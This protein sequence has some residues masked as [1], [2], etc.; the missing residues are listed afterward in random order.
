VFA[1]EGNDDTVTLS[2]QVT[3][4]ESEEPAVS[5]A[6]ESLVG[7][8]SNPPTLRLKRVQAGWGMN[9]TTQGQSVVL[10]AVGPYVATLR[11]ADVTMTTG[12]IVVRGGALQLYPAATWPSDI[13]PYPVPSIVVR[14]SPPYSG[15]LVGMVWSLPPL[16][17]Q[18]G[19]DVE[20]TTASTSTV[21]TSA[22]TWT[23]VVHRMSDDDSPSSVCTGALNLPSLDPGGQPVTRGVSWPTQ[24][25]S[26]PTVLCFDGVTRPT[27][28]LAATNGVVNAAEA[29]CMEIQ[30]S[31][32][33]SADLHILAVR[34]TLY[35]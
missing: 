9:V 16:A 32:E 31:A 22:C 35:P 23:V 26:A 17:N 30:S 14:A 13:S 12:S 19:F 33:Q 1:T 5:Q 24:Q 27:F 8:H 7:E 15:S 28:G 4:L 29:I 10:R 18:M 11:P 25:P 34:L 6:S 3:T 21:T 2:T 20:V